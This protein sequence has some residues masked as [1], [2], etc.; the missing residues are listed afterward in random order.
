MQG[1]T[2]SAERPSRPRIQRTGTWRAAAPVAWRETAP[3]LPGCPRRMAVATAGMPPALDTTL[4]ARCTEPPQPSTTQQAALH[5]TLLRG[6]PTSFVEPAGQQSLNICAP[7]HAAYLVPPWISERAT[8]RTVSLRGARMPYRWTQIGEWSGCWA[9]LDRP[10]RPPARDLLGTICSATPG[11]RS[12]PWDG[13]WRA[14]CSTARPAA[15]NYCV[16]VFVSVQSVFFEPSACSCLEFPLRLPALI[17]MFDLLDPQK[18]VSLHH[19]AQ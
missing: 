4:R 19:V 15:C 8:E 13:G 18:V 11:G 14:S 17:V 9:H 10:M 6:A 7:A 3:P 2:R 16:C 12:S 1:T 5:H